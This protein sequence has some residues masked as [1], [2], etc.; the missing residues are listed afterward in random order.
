MTDNQTNFSL[1]EDELSS[2]IAIAI[3]EDR[4]AVLFTDS[5]REKVRASQRIVE[6]IVNKGDPVYGVNTG[7]GPLCTTSI[8]KEETRTL[9]EN[10]LKSHSV[11]VGKCIDDRIAKLMLVLKAHA[12]AKGYSG[13][14][15][16]T[17]DRIIWHIENNAIPLVPSQGSVGASGDLA[18]LSHLF[19]PLI[20]LGKVSYQGDHISTG[21]LFKKTGLLPLVLGPKEGLA[22]INGTQFISAHAVH[23]LG[24]NASLSGPGRYNRSHDDRRTSGKY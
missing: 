14:S 5:S 8:S 11:G 9:Q 3:A 7:F 24:K 17:L 19:L 18:P 6:K 1:G 4:T 22:L 16:Q 13:I 10:I 15:E 12:L 21:E 2:G 20:G 23:I